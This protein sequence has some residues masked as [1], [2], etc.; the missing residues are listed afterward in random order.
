[1]K[2]KS[3][4]NR[5]TESPFAKAALVAGAMTMQESQSAEKEKIQYEAGVAS[6][7]LEKGREMEAQPWLLKE[8]EKRWGTYGGLVDLPT[9]F[10]LHEALPTIREFVKKYR[11]KNF[12]LDSH[13]VNADDLKV[14]M[15]LPIEKIT[16][17]MNFG[18]EG[19]EAVALAEQLHEIRASFVDGEGRVRMNSVFMD[20]LPHFEIQ[21]AS[22]TAN[23]AVTVL[24]EIN[25]LPDVTYWQKFPIS[26]EHFRLITESGEDMPKRLTIISDGLDG[27]EKSP[28]LVTSPKD[29]ESRFV[30]C[31]T[32]VEADMFINDFSTVLNKHVRDRVIGIDKSWYE[33]LVRVDPSWK[34]RGDVTTNEA[35]WMLERE[36]RKRAK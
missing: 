11:I 29:E 6:S 15:A 36:I 13:S 14:L 34:E 16:V 25:F 10:S 22:M 17:T 18:F 32:Q 33:E 2:E 27:G 12:H 19:Q 26:L 31:N 9:H 23:E 3:F 7:A 8:F 21:T 28:V 24:R 35:V 4:F 20:R 30:S 5:L 1:M